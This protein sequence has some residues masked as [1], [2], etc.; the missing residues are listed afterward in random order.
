MSGITGSPG[1]SDTTTSTRAPRGPRGGA[2]G[3]VRTAE[4][5][6]GGTRRGFAYH[7]FPNPRRIPTGR[8]NRTTSARLARASGTRPPP[9]VGPDAGRARRRTAV[10]ETAVRSR[11]AAAAAAS[12]GSP[13]GEVLDEQRDKRGR[14]WSSPP[15]SKWKNVTND[16]YVKKRRWARA[17][18]RRADGGGLRGADPA[19]EARGAWCSGPTAR[20][21]RPRGWTTSLQRLS[22]DSPETLQ[23]RRGFHRPGHVG[24]HLARGGADVDAVRVRG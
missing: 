4:V 11:A 9:S 14:G 15:E 1:I 7:S 22:R 24:A 13:L 6:P 5:R 12:R 23:S 3:R 16:S 8:T 21:W 17:R 18:R 10:R 2:A 20:S 19:I